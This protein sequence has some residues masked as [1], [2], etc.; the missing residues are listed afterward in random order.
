MDPINT[1]NPLEI[2]RNRLFVPTG[3]EDSHLD[4]ALGRLLTGGV[5]AA[6][7]YFQ[8]VRHESWS[9]EDGMVK[10]GSYS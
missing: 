6:D 5:D 3:L 4:E 9:L 8:Y 10:E 2:A 1:D 7:I